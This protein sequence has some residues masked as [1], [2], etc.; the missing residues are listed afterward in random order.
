MSRRG[1][2]SEFYEERDYYSN[3]DP[4]RGGEVREFDE[5]EYHRRPA[6]APPVREREPARDR[7]LDFLREDHPRASSGQLVLRQKETED[8]EYRRPR[9]RSVVEERKEII[10]R[11]Q[12]R[13]RAD[14][15]EIVF[16]RTERNRPREREVEREE[17]TIR[18]RSKSRE[19]PPPRDF[20]I[21]R[22]QGDRPP[23]PRERLEEREEI[24][25]RE[26][27][28]RPPPK[29]S[30]QIIIRREKKRS[31]SSSPSP[32]PPPEPMP[33][34]P[35]IR[36]PPIHQE[37][38]THHR[39]IDHGFEVVPPPRPM[40]AAPAPL[41]P[42]PPPPPAPRS[43]VDES[44][45][46]RRRGTRADGREY[47]DEI[48]IDRDSR[49]RNRED[50]WTMIPRRRS[51]SAGP[52]RRPAW[53]ERAI[54]EEAEYYDR[55]NRERSY[56]GEGYNGATKDW[57]IVDVPP[58]TKRVEME[59]V[60]GGKEEI[61]WQRY[62]G[63][64]RSKFITDGDEFGPDVEYPLSPPPARE[65]E[66]EISIDRRRYVGVKPKT[67]SMWTEI[68]KD[69]VIKDAIE[70]MGYDYEETED[71]F[72]VMEYLRYED[73]EQ[74][75][76][77]SEDMRRDRRE[78][79]KEIKFERDVHPPRSRRER[80]WPEEERITEREVVYAPRYR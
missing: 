73:V 80:P 61:T 62:N 19:R 27:E 45:E 25:I 69:L 24:T 58:G 65:R 30:E 1:P 37:V 23:P 36:A 14:D 44:I 10:A 78:R 66:R 15:D 50:D 75:V 52:R 12:S 74:L 63:V 56:M 53:E 17:I 51:A 6:P 57:A 68:T 18:D 76:S 48:I 9:A 11:R 8:I 3:R 49:H 39:H 5:Y 16:K 55:K 47:D 34:P 46:I 29:E 41:P 42:P 28:K 2:P 43:E 33:E 72:Y 71:F 22:G 40:S 20:V 79:I 77:L 60:G 32:S 21:R 35:I 67:E 59:G 13:P 70:A 64:R 4:R 26:R 38:I 54:A 7:N 31:P